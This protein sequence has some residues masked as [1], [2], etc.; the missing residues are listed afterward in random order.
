MSH[1]KTLASIVV[2]LTAASCAPRDRTPLRIVDLIRELPAAEARPSRA[3]FEVIDYPGPERA[4][5]AIRTLAPSRLVYTLPM[6][7][8]GVLTA[9]IL[10]DASEGGPPAQPLRFRIGISDDRVYETLSEVLLTPGVQK[11]WT[12]LRVDLSEYAGWKWSVFYRP[13]RVRWRL[14]L[15]TDAATGIPARGVWGLPAIE[16]DRAAAREYVE[17][18]ARGR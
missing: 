15:G 18:A 6:P 14:V 3:A 17:R 16:S 10:I 8:R 2:V 4:Y 9:R 13:D 11:D 5:P 12:E 1:R 7:H